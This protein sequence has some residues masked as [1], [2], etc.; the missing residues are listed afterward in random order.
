MIKGFIVLFDLIDT[1]IE[2]TKETSC[3]E[4]LTKKKIIKSDLRTT[5]K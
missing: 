5:E 4:T 1:V 3:K 2:Y